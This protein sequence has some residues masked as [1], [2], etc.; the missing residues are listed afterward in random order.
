MGEVFKPVAQWISGNVGWTILLAIFVLSLFFEFSKI[1]LSPI[2]AMCH[3]IGDRI[4][5]GLRADIADLKTNTDKKFAEM[6]ADTD[7]NLR[8]LKDGVNNSFAEIKAKTAFNDA[9]FERRQKDIEER[10][11]KLAAARIKAHVL[12]FS[13][14]C[15]NNEKHTLEDFKNLIAENAEYE[16][17]VKKHEWKNDV[18]KEDYAFIMEVYRRCIRDNDFLK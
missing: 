7:A 4:T 10:L 8:D 13:R 12:N 3:W 6:K 17:I 5:S 11:D 16:K 18:Y 14:R 1:K 2:T 15:R 9:E